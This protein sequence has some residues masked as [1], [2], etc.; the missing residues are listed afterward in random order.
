MPKL[1]R[2]A[3]D[4]RYIGNIEMVNE[5]LD[6][7]VMNISAGRSFCLTAQQFLALTRIVKHVFDGSHVKLSA[8]KADVDSQANMLAAIDGSMGCSWWSKS[9]TGFPPRR[10][11]TDVFRDLRRVNWAGKRTYRRRGGRRGV[12]KSSYCAQIAVATYGVT[13]FSRHRLQ[14]QISQISDARK[15]VNYSSPDPYCGTSFILIRAQIR[16]VRSR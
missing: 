1:W 14:P 10:T 5:Y 13:S 2:T 3:R 15:P 6:E 8:P 11:G 4:A 9:D 16:V 12:L 7:Y